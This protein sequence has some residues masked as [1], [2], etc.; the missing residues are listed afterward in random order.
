MQDLVG[1]FEISTFKQYV[2]A[3][4]TNDTL[5]QSNTLHSTINEVEIM[6]Y[7]SVANTVPMYQGEFTLR[8]SSFQPSFAVLE[9]SIQQNE[10]R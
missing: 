10:E 4:L 7:L 2:A 9:N 6:P 5:R 8:W 3:S 1:R